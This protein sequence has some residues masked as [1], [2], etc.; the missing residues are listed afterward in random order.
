MSVARSTR[1][2]LSKTTVHKC[3]SRRKKSGDLF[4]VKKEGGTRYELE[5]TSRS[6]FALHAFCSLL[7]FEDNL[8]RS[9]SFGLAERERMEFRKPISFLLNTKKRL[10]RNETLRFLLFIEKAPKHKVM[11]DINPLLLA[12]LSV[13][14]FLA[15]IAGFTVL[16]NYGFMGFMF[17]YFAFIVGSLEM[18]HCIFDR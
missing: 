6:N 1:Q 2:L 10:I 16:G 8:G 11:Q 7:L 12:F 15:A 18:L 9:T 5:N 4:P 3:G 14:C 17:Y 13:G